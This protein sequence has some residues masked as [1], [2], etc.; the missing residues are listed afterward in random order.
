MLWC[1]IGSTMLLAQASTTS[2]TTPSTTPNP[3]ADSPSIRTPLAFTGVTVVDVT[4]GQLLHRQTVLITGNRITAIGSKKKVKIPRSAKLVDARGKYLIPGMWDMH[5]HV[6]QSADQLYP[7]FV[8]HGVTGLRE[9]AQ[10]FPH[11]TDSFYAWQRAVMSGYRVGPRVI[12]P[13]TDLMYGMTLRTP[14]DARRIMDSLKA[15]KVAFIKFHDSGMRDRNL[16]F[17]IMR[18]ARRVGLPVFGHVPKSVSNVDAADSGQLSVE[19]IEENHQCWPTWPKRLGDSATADARCAPMV[20]AYKRNG[21]YM[22][23]GLNGHWLDDQYRPDKETGLWEDERHFTRMLYRMGFRNF[24]TGT[25]WAPIFA[26]WD[27]RFRA[28]L[29]AVEDLVTLTIDAGLPPLEALQAGTLN[30][31]KV[32]NLTDSLGTVSVGKLADLVLLDGN[33]LEDIRNVLNVRA[34]VVNGHYYNRE[35]LTAMDPV[36]TKP[37]QGLIAA[38]EGR[39]TVPPKPAS[40]AETAQILTDTTQPTLTTEHI[41]QLLAFLHAT[42]QEWQKPEIARFYQAH[43]VKYPIVIGDIDEPIPEQF[44]DAT[45]LVP[46]MVA[47]SDSFPSIKAALTAAKLTA[48]RYMQLHRAILCASLTYQLDRATHRESPSSIDTM[49]TINKNIVFLRANPMVESD[50]RRAGLELPIIR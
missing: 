1:T 36:G 30:P 48:L 11:G 45:T 43:L 3:A 44:Q 2:F 18:E 14:A 50:L 12:G 13:S 49:M 22:M 25:D 33:P 7:L 32:L 10:R 34:V 6:D 39:S 37:D 9:M 24:L 4:N 8:A 20:E 31:A 29:S 46:D 40:P 35:Q 27:Q 19:H 47:L 26:G 5:V 41:S 42:Q 17:S 21:T 38:R 28:G 23:V 16:Y 15:A